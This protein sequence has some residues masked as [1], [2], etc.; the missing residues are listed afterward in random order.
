[1]QQTFRGKLIVYPKTALLTR[2]TEIFSNMD[3]YVIVKC[4]GVTKKSKVHQEGGKKPRWNDVSYLI[5][6]KVFC[7]T[8]NDF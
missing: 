4:G 6:I 2:D 7:F 8:V 3:P 1:M 5:M